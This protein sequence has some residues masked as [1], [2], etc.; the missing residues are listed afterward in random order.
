MQAFAFEPPDGN[1]KIDERLPDISDQ[2]QLGKFAFKKTNI[3]STF[4]FNYYQVSLT[5]LSF[6][7]FLQLGKQP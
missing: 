5:E 2:H 1:N 6:N 3:N 4:L 7:E